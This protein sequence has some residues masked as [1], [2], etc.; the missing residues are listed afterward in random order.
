MDV[1]SMYIHAFI[2]YVLIPFSREAYTRL[3]LML[4][5]RLQ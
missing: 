1:Y 5:L 2:L 4:L 3:G